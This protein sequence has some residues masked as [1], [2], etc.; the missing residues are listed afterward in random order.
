MIHHSQPENLATPADDALLTRAEASE[1]LKQFGIRMKPATLARLWST[2]GDGPP[3]R[4]VRGK[5]LYPRQVLRA[6]A[7]SQDSGLRRSAHDTAPSKG[8]P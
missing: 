8:V 5:P 6:W 2:G 7:E 1:Y 3:C 4:H